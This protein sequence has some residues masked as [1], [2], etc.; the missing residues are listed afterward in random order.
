M[1]RPTTQRARP[2][3]TISTSGNS[4]IAARR[5]VSGK[6]Q[7]LA[8]ALASADGE[9]LAAADGLALAPGDV[10]AA[11]GVGAGTSVTGGGAPVN[12]IAGVGA[13][14]DCGEV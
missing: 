2:R 11:V 6:R 9:P 8:V 4:G 1:V 12:D 5:P 14:P 3:R 7:G 13:E 10:G